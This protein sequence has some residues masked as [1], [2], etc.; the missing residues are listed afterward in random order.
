MICIGYILYIIILDN[1]LLLENQSFKTTIQQLKRENRTLTEKNSE[2]SEL[3]SNNANVG[4]SVDT[5][6]TSQKV[7][8]LEEKIFNLHEELT[9]ALRA[10]SE[11][12]Q[13]QLNLNNEIKK[14]KEQLKISKYE[15]D[16][17][18]EQLNTAKLQY[19]ELEKTLNAKN[20][21]IEMMKKEM[22]A[23]QNDMKTRD[24]RIKALQEE[25]KQM[26]DRIIDQKQKQVDAMNQVNELYRTVMIREQQLALLQAKYQQQS[27]GNPNLSDANNNII[28]TNTN[29]RTNGKEDDGFLILNNETASGANGFNNTNIITAVVK[30]GRSS[31]IS[32]AI[33]I[34]PPK[35]VL[36]KKMTDSQVNSVVFS[37]DS[38]MIA[39]AHN[40]KTVK[41]WNTKTGSI[42]S[43]LYGSSDAVISVSMS[44]NQ[45]WIAGGSTDNICRVWHAGSGRILHAL[46]GHTKK[47]YATSFTSDCKKL[48]TG[49]HDRTIKIWDLQFGA[50]EKTLLKCKS[51]VNDLECCPNTPIFCSGHFDSCARLWDL[52]NPYNL[53]Q[54]YA[55]IHEQQITSVNFSLDGHMI[56]TNARDNTL[57][58]IDI[59][60]HKVLHTLTHEDYRNNVN[61]N[62]AVLS[63]CRSY[64]IAGS[65]GG[66]SSGP[67]CYI[68]NID[69]GKAVTLDGGHKQAITGCAWSHDGATIASVSIDKHLIIYQ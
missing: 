2:L 18:K 22:E 28:N 31:S 16:D 50:C 39:T 25:N 54:E 12:I 59:R 21:T 66:P 27:T 41:L 49:S 14:L 52:R 45:K 63:P 7:K 23:L 58:C 37:Q 47:I 51:S 62:K 6:L 44:S 24:E 17:W 48:I 35:Q 57:K 10:K 33:S 1:N 53:I 4:N 61:Q 46:T 8:Q 43:T 15:S 19:S 40:D 65:S 30:S 56:L 60:M 32:E 68:W 69:E 36:Y 38:T 5:I 11:S 26:I 64:A 29:N 55:N 3:V 13:Q 20:N 67:V 42:I 34:V 9:A